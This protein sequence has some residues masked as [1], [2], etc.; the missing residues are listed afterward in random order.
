MIST[1]LAEG[2]VYSFQQFGYFPAIPTSSWFSFVRVGS[3]FPSMAGIRMSVTNVG[4]TC[5]P[6]ALV[7]S[8]LVHA[9]LIPKIAV[10]AIAGA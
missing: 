9:V 1:S 5:A 7:I 4:S 3:I 10:R 2:A 8:W 6:V